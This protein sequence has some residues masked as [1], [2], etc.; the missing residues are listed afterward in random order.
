MFSVAWGVT[1]V[2]IY[3]PTTNTPPETL[4]QKIIIIIIIIIIN[5]WPESASELY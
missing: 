5:P 4:E 1:S 3:K 2:Y